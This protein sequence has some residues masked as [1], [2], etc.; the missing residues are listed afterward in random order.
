VDR[1]LVLLLVAAVASASLAHLWTRWRDRDARLERN[2]DTGLTLA[3]QVT[4]LTTEVARLR[5]HVHK[6]EGTTAGLGALVQWLMAVRPPAGP[7]G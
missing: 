4:N 6:L 5:D 7:M 3:Q 2:H 1:D